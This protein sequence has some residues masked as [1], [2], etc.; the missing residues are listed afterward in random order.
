[1]GTDKQDMSKLPDHPVQQKGG[2]EFGRTE[3]WGYCRTGGGS[4]GDCEC[5]AVLVVAAEKGS[6]SSPKGH[7]YG[8]LQTSH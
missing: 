5:G 1:M 6:S 4:S 2:R 8:S 3:S 7:C